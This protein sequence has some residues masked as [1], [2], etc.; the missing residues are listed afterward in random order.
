MLNF[1][2]NGKAAAEGGRAAL[3]PASGRGL[4]SHEAVPAPGIFRF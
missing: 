4:Q 3:H 2:R 1:I